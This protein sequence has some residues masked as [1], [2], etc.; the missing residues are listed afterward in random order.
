MTSS[1]SPSTRRAW[2]PYVG[3]A[4]SGLVMVASVWL[5]GKY[6]GASTTFV[7]AAG[8]LESL[9]APEY[10]ASLAY[11]IK[12]APKLDWQGMFLAGVF[13]GAL[14]AAMSSRTFRWTA[15]PQRWETRFG[16]SRLRR[17]VTAFVGGLVAMF[18]ARLA[19]G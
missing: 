6:F 17:G 5:A 4:L 15:L 8:G 16:P 9:V 14:G 1:S 2:S 13:L 7:R 11:F 10:V 12:E 18:G 3:G 19:D